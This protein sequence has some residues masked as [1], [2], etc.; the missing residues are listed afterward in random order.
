MRELRKKAGLTFRADP[1]LVVPGKI[2][3]FHS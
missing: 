1:T 3:P 2:L